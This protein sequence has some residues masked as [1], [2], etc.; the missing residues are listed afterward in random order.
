MPQRKDPASSPEPGLA[1]GDGRTN[2]PD[3]AVGP[4]RRFRDR[5]RRFGF[6][7]VLCVLLVSVLVLSSLPSFLSSAGLHFGLVSA[8]KS[9]VKE[10][11][12]KVRAHTAPGTLNA[13]TVSTTAISLTW[14]DNAKDETAI[15]IERRD[16]TNQRAYRQVA[17]APPDTISYLDTG[18]DPGATYFYRLRAHT[19]AGWS[20]Y[21]NEASTMTRPVPGPGGETPG[22]DGEDPGPIDPDSPVISSITVIPLAISTGGVTTI[23]CWAYSPVGLQPLTYSWTAV[24]GGV[25]AGTGNSVTWTA[26]ASSGTYR[27]RL[28]VGD[29]GVHTPVK[30]DILVYVGNDP[31]IVSLDAE[32]SKIST[33]TVTEVVCIAT[34][35]TGAMLSY[36]WTAASG[37]ISGVGASV[38]W[39]A[40]ESTGTYMISCEVTDSFGR[41]ASSTTLV[42]VNNLEILSLTAAPVVVSTGGT[43]AVSCVIFDPGTGPITYT[44][45]VDGGTITGA[46]A[47]VTWEAPLST[48]SFKISCE[49]TD[50]VATLIR[51]L[52]VWSATGPVIMELTATPTKVSTGAV[53]AI[54]CLAS[55][56][57][58]GELTYVWTAA[59]GTITQTGTA[60]LVTWAAP[61]STGIYLV[62]IEVTD[63]RGVS[64]SSSVPV[65]VSNLQ[66]TSLTAMPAV[67]STGAVSGLVCT[68]AGPANPDLT[69]KWTSLDGLIS[70]TGASVTW[71]APLTVGKYSVKC[72]VSDG[73][74]IVEREVDVW[75]ATGPV[76]TVMLSDVVKVATGAVANVICIASAPSAGPLV[77]TWTAA[78]GTLSGT[79]YTVAWTAPLTTGTYVLNVLVADEYGVTASSSIALLVNNLSITS[80]TARPAVV[81]TG[82]VSGVVCLISGPADPN[83]TY[84]WTPTGGEITGTGAS[85]TWTAPEEIGRYAIRCEVTD[86]QA[87]VAKD[88]DLWAATGPVIISL[89]AGDVKLSTGADTEIVC[90]ASAPS[91]GPLVYTWTAASGTITGTG[92][93]ISWTAPLTTGTYIVNILVADEFGITVSSALAMLV[94]NLSIASLTAMPAVVYTSSEAQVL[95]TVTGPAG[96]DLVYTWMPSGGEITGTGAAVTWTA[97][98]EI[99]AYVIKCEVTDGIATVQQDVNVWSATGPVIISLRPDEV[100]LST[101]AATDIVCLASAPSSGPLTYVWTAASGTINGSG[102]DVDWTAPLSTGVYVINVDVTDMYGITVSSSLYMLVNNLSITSLTAMPAVVSTGGVSGVV[103][104]VSGPTNPDLT[105]TWTTTDGVIN[106]TGASVTWTAPLEPGAHSI[107]CEVTDGIATVQEEVD[108]W[109]ATGPVIIS[110]RAESLKISTGAATDIIC[111]A[112]APSSGPLSYV[113]TAASGTITG[114]GSSASWTAP[115]STGIYFISVEVE[116]QYNVKASSQLAIVVSNLVITSLTAMPAVVSTGA[117]SGVTCLVSPAGPGLTYTWTTTGGAIAGTGA[118]VTW[119][120]PL[121]IGGYTIKCDVSD[122]LATLSREVDVWAATGPVIISILPEEVKISTGADTGIVC[123]ASAPSAGPL[124]YTWT[125]ASGTITGTLGAANWTAPLSTGIY[126]ITCQ[127]EDE[128]HVTASTTISIVVSNLAITSLTAMPGVVST[129]GVSGVVCTVPVTEGVTYIWTPTGGVITGTGASVTW[130]APPEI[131]TYTIRCEV[132]DGLATLQQQVAVWAATGPVIISLTADNVILSTGSDTGIVCVASAPGPG[133]LT[134]TWT[135]ASGTVTSTLGSANWAAP[136]TT[137]TYLISLD[138]E[139]EFHVVKSTTLSIVVSNLAMALTASPTVIS[140]SEVSAITCSVSGQS[141]TVTYDWTA[142]SGTITGT[143]AVVDWTAPESSGTYIVN[144]AVSDGDA[145]VQAQVSILV[146][147]GPVIIS[148]TADRPQLSTGTTTEVVCLATAPGS[149]NLTYVWTADSG[150]INGSGEA[151]DWT[152]PDSTGTYQ[153]SCEVTG[154]RPGSA[155]RSISVLV[156]NPPVISSISVVPSVVAPD[157]A[158]VLTC[159]AHDP[160]NP[161]LAYEWNPASGTI[162]GTGAAVNWTAPA[163][164]GTYTVSCVVADGEGGTDSETVS[165]IV[166]SLP[167]ILSLNAEPNTIST[168]ATSALRCEALAAAGGAL[169]YNW[170]A[171]SGTITGTGSQVT[172][173]PPVSTG[174]YTISCEVVETGIGSVTRSLNVTVNNPPVISSVT[175]SPTVVSTAAVS[176][177]T[178]HVTDPDNPVLFYTWTPSSGSISG[179]GAAVNWTAPLSSGIYTVTCEVSDG[180]GGVDT[181][182]VTVIVSSMPVIVSLDA[183]PAEISTGTSSDL[184]CDA[185][186]PGDVPLAYNWIAGSGTITGTGSN[187]TWT[188]PVSVGTFTITCEVSAD[189]KSASRSVN[190]VVNNPPTILSL[191]SDPA[192]VSM[193]HISTVTCVTADPGNPAYIY[194]WDKSSGTLTGSGTEVYWTAPDSSGTYMIS[195]EVSDGAGGDAQKTLFITVSSV[196]VIDSL[197]ISPVEVSTGSQANLICTARAPDNGAL[198]YNWTPGSGTITGTGSQVSWTAPESTGTYMISCAVSAWGETASQ[199]VNVLVNNPPF[200][201]SMTADPETVFPLNI[202]TVSCWAH[203]P[204]NPVLTYVWTVSSGAYTEFAPGRIEWTAP[205]ST[206]TYNIS[207]QA[208]DGEGGSAEQDVDIEVSSLPVIMNIS[209]FPDEVSTGTAT[210]LQCDA[211]SPG[212][213]ALSYDW[214]AGSGTLSGSGAAVSWMA[215]VSTGTYTIN[216][217]VTDAQGSIT[218]SVNVLVNNPPV[219]SS[220]TAAP[221]VVSPLAVSTV[222]CAAQDP[223]NAVLFYSW[224]L[225]GGTYG[226]LAPGQIRWTAPLSTGAYNLLCTA[227]DGEGGEDQ[228]SVEVIVSSLP[229]IRSL[230]SEPNSV[231]TGGAASL[232]CVALAPD[233][234]ELSY[235]WVV[236]SGTITGTGADVTWTAPESTGTYVIRCEVSAGG[237]MVAGGVPVLVNNPP[238]IDGMF[239]DPASLRPSGISTVTCSAHDPDNF[240]LT[241]GWQVSGGTYF[242]LG[243]GQARWEAPAATGS[244]TVSCEVTD[245]E[246]GRDTDSMVVPVSNLPVISALVAD[247]A[248]VSTGA[249]AALSCTAS[250]PDSDPLTYTWT[251]GSGTITGTG[252]DVVWTAPLSTGTYMIYCQ[253]SDGNGGSAQESVNVLVNNP[254]V[255]SSLVALPPVISSGEVSNITCSADDPDNTVLNYEWAAG[256][257]SITGT[258]ATIAW[259]A[260][261]SSGTYMVGC[262][263]SDGE[264]G[265]DQQSVQVIVSSL[266]VIVSLTADPEQVSTGTAADLNCEA[267]DPAGGTPVYNWSAASGTVNGTGS[268]VTWTA[269]LTTG[270]Y[271][272]TCQ[273]VGGNGGSVQQDVVI[274]VN[275]PPVI[276]SLIAVPAVLLPLEISTLTCTATD[277]DNPVIYT[278]TAGSGTISGLGAEVYW[279][280]PASTGTYTI[281]CEVSDGEGGTD[282]R[283]VNVAVRNNAPPQVSLISASPQEISAFTNSLITCLASDPDSD[284]LSYTWTAASGTLAGTG[285]DV[286]WTAPVSTGL[287]TINC[288]VSDAFSGVS[289][290]VV[291]N[292]NNPPVINSLTADPDFISPLAISTLT[293][294]ASDPD[295]PV[296]FYLWTASS[297]TVIGTGYQVRWQAPV[298]SGAY[299]VNC[300]VS[301]GGSG[302]VDQNVNLSVSSVP[303][304]NLLSVAPPQVSTGAQAA[305]ICQAIAPDDLVPDYTWLPASG[306][307]TGTGTNVSWTAPDSTGTYFITCQASAGGGSVSA[308]TS[309]LVNN[310][311]VIASLT[312]DPARVSPLRVSTVTCSAH[313]P[314][315]PVLD[316]AWNFTGG[317][318]EETGTVGQVRW[319][320]P[321]STG[322]Y[323]AGCT[324]SDGEGGTAQQNTGIIVASMPVILSLIASPEM[325]STGAA[326]GLNCAAL[327]SDNVEPLYTWTP[328]SGTITGTGASV[329][330]TAPVST[331]TYMIFCEV[332]ADGKTVSASVNVLVNNPPVITSLEAAPPNVQPTNISTV[333]CTA[334]DPDN[335]VISYVWSVSTGAYADLGGGQIRWTAPASTGSCNVTCRVSDGE[336]G[337]AQQSISIT[338]NS[339]PDI[340]SLTAAPP[341]VTSGG[342]SVLTCTAVDPEGGLLAYSWLAA[343]GTIN[344]NTFEEDWTAPAATGAYIV[345]CQVTDGYNVV[346]A[347]V[348]VSVN[349][350]P[351]ITSTG[352]APGM[353]SP[354]HVST[355]TCSATDPDDPVLTYTWTPAAGTIDGTGTE[356]YWTAPASTGSYTILLEVSDGENIDEAT[357]TVTVSSLP[358]ITSLTAAPGTVSTGTSAGLSCAAVAPDDAALDYL[359]IPGSGTVTGTG[360]NVQW[361]APESTGTY[362]ITCRVTSGGESVEQSVNVFV[363]NPPVIDSL[364]GAPPALAPLE[365]STIT[366]AAHDPDNPVLIYNWS[367]ASGTISGTGSEIYWTAPASTA[368]YVISCTVSDGEGGEA[369]SSVNITV[370]LNEPPAIGSLTAFPVN[371]STN[372]ASAITC[373]ATDPDND[374][375]AYVWSAGSGTI[376]GTGNVVTWTPPDTVGLYMITCDVSDGF[377][378]AAS[379]TT[380]VAVNNPPLITSMLPDPDLVS[381]LAISSLTCSATDPDG[382][383]M[384]FDWTATSGTITGTAGAA[385]W[386][387][388]DATGTYSITCTVSD[389]QGG[390]A[391]ASRQII[392][393]SLPLITELR[394]MPVTI[395]SGGTVDLTCEARAPDKLVPV[396]VWT[397]SGGTIIGTGASV[398]W[399]APVLTGVYLITCEVQAG[400]VSASSSTSV[401]V[402]NVP[403][404]DSLTA[405]PDMVSPLAVSTVTCA[406]HDP[407][408]GELTYDWSSSSG[409]YGTIAAGQLRWAAPAATGTYMVGCTVSDGAG[410]EDADSLQIRVSSLP[411]INSLTVSSAAVSTGVPVN[412]ECSALAPDNEAITYNW[413]AGSGTVTGTG[414]AVVWTSPL[415][416]GTY[417][418]GCEVSAGGQT[419]VRSTNILVNNPPVITTMTAVPELVDLLGVSTITCTAQDPDGVP[420]TYGWA[421]T[422]GTYSDL[423]G[424]Q[425]RWTAPAS[426]VTCTVTCTV[427]D[428]GG[429]TDQETVT[430]SARGNEAPVIASISAAPATVPSGGTASITCTASDSDGD[431]LTYSWS[432]GSGTITGTGLNIS[433][434]SPASTGT[435]TI[436]CEVNDGRG[437]V[438]SGSV[439]VPVNNPPSISALTAAPDFVSPL[440]VSTIT[441]TAT[442][443]DTPVLNYT[444]DAASGTISGT[445]AE[446]YWTAPAATGSYTISCEVSDGDGGSAQ[447]SETVLVSSVPRVDWIIAAPTKISSASVATLEIQAQGPDEGGLSYTW[448]AASGTVSG[449]GEQAAWTA[450]DSTG[451]YMISCQVTALPGGGVVTVSTTVLVNN[452]PVVQSLSGNPERVSPLRVS[453]LTCTASDPDNSL[454]YYSWSALYGTIAGTGAQVD[455]TAPDSTG[456]YTV[457]CEVSDGEGGSSSAN[458]PLT[459]SSIPYITSVTPS[460][461][462][463]ST[464]TSVNLACV[465]GASDNDTLSYD[466]IIGSGTITGT[467]ATVSWLAPASTGTYPIACAV[468]AVPGG[469]RAQAATSVLVNNPPVIESLAAVPS[470]LSTGAVS[471]VTCTA[472]DPDNEVLDYSWTAASGTITGTGS[473]ISW[474]APSSSGSFSI[475]CSV[476]DGEGGLAQQYTQVTVNVNGEPVISSLTPDD[477][478]V[479][480]SGQTGITCAAADPDDPILAYTWTPGSGT[481]TGTGAYV[482]WDAPASTGTYMIRCEVTDGHSGYDTETVNILVNNPPAITYMDTQPSLLLPSAVS[483]VTCT[484]SDPDNPVIYGWSATGG[485]TETISATQIRWRAPSSTGTYSVTCTASDGEGGS[486]QRTL[487]VTVSSMPVILGLDASPATVST[488][489]LSAI[490]CDAEMPGGGALTYDWTAASG[491]ITGTGAGVTWAA[492]NATGTYV[493]GCAVSA[494]A[495]T[496][497][498][499][500]LLYVNNQPVITALTAVPTAVSPSAIST[501]TC[502]ANDPDNGALTYNWSYTGGSFGTIAAGQIRWT[503][504][505]STGAYSITCQVTDPNNGSAQNSVGVTVSSTPVILSLSASPASVLAGGQSA[506]TC[507]A[508]DPDDDDTLSYGW[509]A[510]SGTITG[511]G[512]AVTWTSPASSGTYTVGCTVSDGHGGVSVRSVPIFVGGVILWTK[513]L[514]TTSAEEGTA[515]GLDS[516]GDIYIA[517]MTA[518]SLQGTNK[519][520]NDLF[521]TKYGTDGTNP[522][523]VQLGTTTNDVARGLAVYHSSHVFV[524][525]EAAGPLDDNTHFGDLDFFLVK[526]STAGVKA[527]SRQFGTSVNEV[528]YGV[529]VDTSGSVYI[530][531][532]TLGDL[533]G[534]GNQG[535]EDA[536][537]AKYNA[538][539]TQV[540]MKQLGTTGKDYARGVAVDP[541]GNIVIAG[542]TDAA[543]EGSS[544]GEDDIFIAKYNQA[545]DNIWLE[546]YGTGSGEQAYGVAVDTSGNV[547]VTGYTYGDFGA[548]NLGQ[549]DAFLAKYNSS[550]ASVWVRQLGSTIYDYGRA[551]AVDV[552]GNVFYTGNTYGSFDGNTPAGDWDVIL[553]KYDSSGT[554]IWSKQFGTV[555]FAE[556][557]QGVAVDPTGNVFTT[558]Y[559]M[560]SL[561]GNTNPNPG[562]ADIFL[563]KHVQ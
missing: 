236:G 122:G 235:N 256:S 193:G 555:T 109:A 229:I 554:K 354:L 263:V 307:I 221:A 63:S 180:E 6:W 336:G 327:V 243:G 525:G 45:D 467:G 123:V 316:Y 189:G 182:F 531:G 119:T 289:T 320:A 432:A 560:G 59:S 349:N 288:V 90:L 429:G 48:G 534:N 262:T 464:G 93:T 318:Y 441:C 449:T 498:R 185:Y 438:V 121:E 294:S 332:S 283:P 364:T 501:I 515:V 250:D 315:N 79:G 491:T 129:G 70:G 10:L 35:S 258:G 154:S 543:L 395:S 409:S 404:L 95:C 299:V 532:Y 284:P 518:G 204:D 225:D 445:G 241:Y 358:S 248:E 377:G 174:A 103:C 244:Y 17:V 502:T 167:I 179:T 557:G 483:T 379:S 215:P 351:V 396:Y 12:V 475:G 73:L 164:T 285:S 423:G 558:G 128:F 281:G 479:P 405:E 308:S 237:Q 181:G 381:P 184:S 131:G 487:P 270:T 107:T 497:S 159:F 194:T 506:V 15:A 291:V 220:V 545:G 385:D 275:N 451:T 375:L 207:C 486:D 264:G 245:G 234:E 382:D 290:S 416:T 345:A 249:T 219:I 178:C 82:A 56:P 51:E 343:S 231:S 371:I 41:S 523:T 150:T 417:T 267:Y 259:T 23:T 516:S 186:A 78:S 340:Q 494:G 130:T 447:L 65:M 80:L 367:A 191:T 69:Y 406:A 42:L 442:D 478:Y 387:A 89:T 424:G 165:I 559:T 356:V 280:A 339:V 202:S 278:W 170:A 271:H 533:D 148:L 19:A 153:I 134:Y 240:V 223:D 352:V 391:Q 9:K 374:P 55:S 173:S 40:P 435:Y 161:V 67:I 393:S 370:R 133:P 230:T 101:G 529:A 476:S 305:L 163:A 120:A 25:I 118:E 322:S 238:V 348:V 504:P 117:A 519:G 188:A 388:P 295:T 360:A 323:T 460:P 550:G 88:V 357:L 115:L 13:M 199:S 112:S 368:V 114:T 431:P 21:S 31:V 427:S 363:N 30:R 414:A 286:V 505:A 422:T 301:D 331:G 333:T 337:E 7:R 62:N 216:C 426:T 87:T 102:S 353:V 28:K 137:G 71:T 29:G 203:D 43:S 4:L 503:A 254:P 201:S 469:G 419:V 141:A 399:T 527:W 38:N 83:L 94:N 456:V 314:D 551:I 480:T 176:V 373:L 326:A 390:S 329:S 411:I 155:I 84:T 521:L 100:K 74:D 334:H 91:A 482:T 5:L 97:P 135:A 214:Q 183:S 302:S 359:W 344:G 200:I 384:T 556:S 27:V 53:S 313:D 172:W 500:V 47:S 493:V 213:T 209:A 413:L 420:L 472:D 138:I 60:G 434:A 224:T 228:G 355:L 298:S 58:Q 380:V 124:V 198:A 296:L 252:S 477:T 206:G 492:P 105:Y 226:T 347:S 277:P 68:V 444:W 446:A 499:N 106:G 257:G 81:S 537:L 11:A 242:D 143:G 33:G 132:T 511:T 392:V 211:Y 376:T 489:A 75:A 448:S 465:A 208:S 454:L 398:D 144:C 192:M 386:T 266:P 514:G 239:A 309:V 54:V 158:S 455:W 562:S 136:L 142:A 18:L 383:P 265:E 86:G 246:G 526:Y 536:F 125:S 530:A 535:Q 251:P 46:G 463:T 108:V 366:C 116:D 540:W 39:A 171:G 57:A 421:V 522:W 253:V 64:T 152:A 222:T 403:V 210:A 524:V 342:T 466:W 36:A 195:C 335:S 99:G 1:P 407:D 457:N 50:G 113:W 52:E 412:L 317:T 44:W 162:T 175:A 361:T 539:G 2:A 338:I 85:V 126:M 439:A 255:I 350:P 397:P 544:L 66:I 156:N 233:D 378:G 563:T 306:T 145:T 538:S 300:E 401:Q 481:I 196:P 37:T 61:L 227:A 157:A 98:A 319:T 274:L 512:A 321:D 548:A 437:G 425:I 495:G 166:S 394:A 461:T 542:Y 520:A 443:P 312:T 471:V 452:P 22:G 346:T 269:P 92:D 468:T 273:V 462:K 205:A 282:Y 436:N 268:A 187:V 488:G 490:S 14:K 303:V 110:L 147:T 260:P 34:T 232:H 32:P 190:I 459:V 169:T 279:R 72:E 276:S 8:V 293:C 341:T 287:Y 218:G 311:P 330:W 517:G 177:I 272:I 362:M 428:G 217:R 546:Q 369:S 160:D 76:I 292:V 415:T 104:L 139:D 541:S 410:G 496:V 408:G 470:I 430:V 389:D 197:A 528:A 212:N 328:G 324:V 458:L 111:L 510:A 402:N 433:W 485:S 96:P 20:D 49:V 553:V 247:P 16:L 310:P 149:G 365:I 3:G 168:S 561:E 507:S 140:T 26:P 146:A 509:S 450:P 552:T 151:V 400:A 24:D 549:Q 484:A 453:T 325:V 304:I 473:V 418:L 297:G 513:Q 547:Y 261:E 77:Y 372:A 474:T 508:L 440:R 127:V